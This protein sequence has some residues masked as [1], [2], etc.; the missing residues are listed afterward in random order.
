M[1]LITGSTGHL[2]TT[3]IGNLLKNGV[4]AKN[5]A[6]LAR[7]REKA[8]G[9]NELGI[10]IRF[11]NYD[12]Y[13]SLKKAFINVERLLFI[14]GSEVDKRDKQHHNI[15][16]AAVETKVPHI[17][18][19]SFERRN[20]D[21][22]IP[23]AFVTRTH[24]ETERKILETGIPY[25]FLRNALYAEG[26]PL[27]LGDN[28]IESGVFFPA[29]DG[30]VPFTS[31]LNLAE[32]TANILAGTGHENKSYYMVNT[33]NYSFYEIAAILSEIT[34]KT[35]KYF[36]PSKEEF[37]ESLRKK[38]VPE[39]TIKGIVAWGDGISQGYFESEYSDLEM[40]L[41]RKPSDLKT[42]LSDMYKPVARETVE[43]SLM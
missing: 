4:P 30:R 29:G 22:N 23:I 17:I 15:V 38:C 2:G 18:Y 10:E 39:E 19:T 6:A 33:H 20:D 40:F 37:T 13:D 11:G 8:E 3:V 43:K 32:A 26:L 5:I 27:F 36:C 35:I 7:N 24:I 21:L 28:V 1:I 12:D 31:R 34:G 42:V 41:G 25:T 9:L 14:S 16:K